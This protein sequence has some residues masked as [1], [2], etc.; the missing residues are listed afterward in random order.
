MDVVI[1]S[2]R[3]TSLSSSSSLVLRNAPPPYAEPVAS[4]CRAN[5]YPLISG[6]RIFKQK[7][8]QVTLTLSVLSRGINVRVPT[9]FILL[10]PFT[11]L[12]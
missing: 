4:L 9:S 2:L 3:N 6:K 10:Y 5:G 1:T 11:V 8:D 7:A 12:T